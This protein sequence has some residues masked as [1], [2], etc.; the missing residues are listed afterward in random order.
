MKIPAFACFLICVFAVPDSTPAPD[1]PPTFHR[2]K[3]GVSLD[4]QF[5]RCPTK[6]SKYPSSLFSPYKDRNG[7]T[8]PCF[9]ELLLFKPEPYPKVEKI[10]LVD[11]MTFFQDEKGNPV[12]PGRGTPGLPD[13]WIDVFVPASKELGEGTVEGVDLTYAPSESDRVKTALS[14]KFGAGHSLDNESGFMNPAVVGL[15]GAKVISREGWK[16][17]WGQVSLGITDQYVLAY[18]TTSKLIEFQ[19]QNKKDEF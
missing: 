11:L 2:I 1:Q 7:N 3:L 18:A 4:S 10:R 16:T 15:L 14:K 12:P 6:D 19:R 17:D 5:Q 13:V 9:Y 8:I